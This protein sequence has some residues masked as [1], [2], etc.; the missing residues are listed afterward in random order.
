MS[1]TKPPHSAQRWPSR[2]GEYTSGVEEE[3]S[4]GREE[5]HGGLSSNNNNNNN[6]KDE[7]E[8]EGS[9]VHA[10]EARAEGFLIP[11]LSVASTASTAP[12]HGHFSFPEELNDD[13]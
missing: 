10:S 12:S 4:E 3:T 8:T 7:V 6:S 13:V 9:E 2:S 11:S 1:S 5:C